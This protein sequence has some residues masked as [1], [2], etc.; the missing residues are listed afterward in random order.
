MELGEVALGVV[1][2]RQRVEVDEEERQLG[3]DA[4]LLRHQVG[5]LRERLAGDADQ[6]L[7]GRVLEELAED[8][9]GAARLR[10]R[11]PARSASATSSASVGGDHL[12][13]ARRFAGG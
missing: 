4:A 8:G 13:H 3:L 10:R 7:E 12:A 2:A 6:R 9:A 11:S 1:A 5:M